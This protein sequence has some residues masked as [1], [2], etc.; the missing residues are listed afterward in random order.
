M[1]DMLGKKKMIDIRPF[2]RGIIPAC[3]FGTRMNMLPH[4]SKEML[5]DPKTNQPLIQYHLDICKKYN[6]APLVI[7]RKIK[8]DLIKY[9]I[10]NDIDHI[11][12]DEGGSEWQQTILLTQSLWLTYNFLFLPDTRFEPETI[13]KDMLTSLKL[14]ANYVFALHP[15]KDGAKWGIV[16]NYTL[17]EKHGYFGEIPENEDQNYD[18][19]GIIAFHKECGEE[20]FKDSTKLNNASFCFL[21]KF[22]DLTRNGKIED[23]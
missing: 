13:I 7:T 19:W 9:L 22:I 12:L 16:Q 3:G 2:T 8:K 17:F 1:M 20:L 15:V 4:E 5:I 11:A 6:I 14:G 23:Y 21:N 18:A 10:D